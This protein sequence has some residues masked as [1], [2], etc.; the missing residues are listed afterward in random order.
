[1]G[2]LLFVGWLTG[3]GQA[4]YETAQLSQISLCIRSQTVA[5]HNLRRD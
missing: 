3:M 2:S 1:M 4:D 5:R